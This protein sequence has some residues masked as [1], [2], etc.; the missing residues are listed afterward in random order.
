MEPPGKILH[1]DCL[2]RDQRCAPGLGF[3]Q[4]KL[5]DTTA[6]TLSRKDHGSGPEVGDCPLCVVLDKVG[7]G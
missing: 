1:G 6:R 5:H 7:S 4:E 3:L 2:R